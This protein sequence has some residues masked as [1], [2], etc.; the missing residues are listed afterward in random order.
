MK[1]AVVDVSGCQYVEELHQRIQTALDFPDYYGGNPD[2]FWD[3]INRDCD[4]DF[5]SVVGVA[6]IA[7][8]LQPTIQTIITLLEENKQYWADSDCPFDYE[9]ID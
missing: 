5:V 3:C 6:H 8:A 9:I 2:A 4:A 1:K 7:D